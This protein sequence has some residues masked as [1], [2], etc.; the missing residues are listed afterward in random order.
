MVAGLGALFGAMNPR[1]SCR[2]SSSTPA[3]GL[4]A[5]FLAA[6]ALRAVLAPQKTPR[7]ASPPWSRASPPHL[8]LY[9][10]GFFQGNGFLTLPPPLAWARSSSAR[11]LVCRRLGRPHPHTPPPQDL[12]E[13]YFP[14]AS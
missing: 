10:V 13:K 8:S 1:N 4:A 2:T 14:E 3:G 7:A 12:V 11:G 9:R 6:V 5:C